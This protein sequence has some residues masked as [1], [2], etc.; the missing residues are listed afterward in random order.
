MTIA[1]LVGNPNS[2]K[3][4][5]FNALTGARQMIGNWPGVT[6]ARKAGTLRQN[7]AVTVQDLPG[8]YSL[9]PYSTEERITRDYLLSGE[10]DV[11]VNVVDATNLERNLYLTLQVMETGRPL[12]VAL[13]MMDVL[14]KQGRE[15]NLTKLAYALRV[16]VIGISATQHLHL[17]DLTAAMTAD[18]AAYP[19]PEYDPRVESALAMI[20][21]QLTDV[22]VSQR[23]WYAIKLFEHD[24]AVSAQLALTAAQ[25]AEIDATRA[26]AEQLFADSADSIIVNARYDFIARLMAMCVVDE[27]SFTASIS[28]RIDRVVTNRFL[29][30][31]IFAA[32]MWAVYYLSIQT[33]G[34]LG[35][36][37]LNDTVFGSWLPGVM[38]QTLTSWHVATWLQSLLVDGI[39]GGVG[40]V[41]GFLPQIMMLFLCLGLL[42]DCGYM[43]RIA[44]VMDRV[45]H[46]FHLS[47]KAFIPMLIAT[48]CGVPG[49]MATRTI[50]N[51]KDRK[52]SIMLT[53]FMPCSA[54]LAII[55]M[56]SGTFFPHQSW[57]APSAYFIG[58]LA[59]VCSGIFLK[60]TRLFAGP[61]AP[62]VMELPAYHLPLLANVWRSV[63]AR[64]RA[65]VRKAGSIIFLSCVALW[66]LSHFNWRLKWVGQNDSLLRGLGELLAPVLAPLGFGNWQATVATLAGLIAKENCVGTL[67]IALG[68][69]NFG[70]LLRQTYAPMAGYAFLVFNLLCAPCFAAIGAM[71]REFG[72]RKWTLYAIAYQ[73]SVAYLLALIVYQGS[74]AVLGTIS[75][76]GAVMLVAALGLLLYG[77]WWRKPVAASALATEEKG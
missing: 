14:A 64:A 50:E 41:L 77:L 7:P 49:I 48:G 54:K 6:V 25:T 13:N 26:T 58:I 35:S 59:V 60:K 34:T 73:T 57:V 18:A 9:S 22:P 36:D 39:V 69:G 74:Q 71:Y 17:A 3:T 12:V 21:A 31:P 15:I 16:P 30:L 61:P 52:M 68:P 46:R 65:F 66:W 37:W 62:F 10:A 55:A 11:V 53:T 5:L 28:D 72:E 76:G 2:G 44:F 75:A 24:E 43:A 1:A 33:I 29:A 70:D 20:A 38:T 42:E 45:F 27:L 47:G 51:S 32:V 8:T 40:A 19:Y 67:R 4:T 23:R 63:W 56:V